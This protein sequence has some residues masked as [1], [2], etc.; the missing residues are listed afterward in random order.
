MQSNRGRKRLS[1]DQMVQYQL[2]LSLKTI[3][4]AKLQSFLYHLLFSKEFEIAIQKSLDF[5]IQ[6]KSIELVKSQN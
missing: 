3:N 2:K 4:K 5:L 1:I 6:I